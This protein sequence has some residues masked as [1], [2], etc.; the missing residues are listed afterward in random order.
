LAWSSGTIAI[1]FSS[2]HLHDD[3]LIKMNGDHLR[4]RGPN[5]I[6]DP[7]SGSDCC[8]GESDHGDRTRRFPARLSANLVDL[9]LQ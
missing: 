4:S 9:R 2:R 3:R 7:C 6:G 8:Q 1:C 5:Q